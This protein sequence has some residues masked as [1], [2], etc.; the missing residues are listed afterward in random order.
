M[1]RVAAVA[2]GLRSTAAAAAEAV[3][4]V[5]AAATAAAAV[6]PNAPCGQSPAPLQKKV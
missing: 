4:A 2:S 6:T 3:T 5:Y 1:G